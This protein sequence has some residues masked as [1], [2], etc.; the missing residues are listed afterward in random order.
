MLQLA[1]KTALN[2][3]IILGSAAV[4]LMTS[5]YF[6]LGGWKSG[7][8]IYPPSNITTKNRLFPTYVYNQN[9]LHDLL[10][11]KEPL[12]LNFTIMADPKSNKLTQALYDILGN[13]DQYPLNSNTNPCNLASVA[14]DS[15]DGRDLM[16]TYGVNKIPSLV[17]LHK[18][19]PVGRYVSPTEDINYEDLKRWISENCK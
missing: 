8:T 9:E 4:A 10:L 14:V 17:C 1:T 19:I 3:K 6:F 16:L 7:K 15:E 5:Q 11:F 12:I 18:Q 2:R 13:K